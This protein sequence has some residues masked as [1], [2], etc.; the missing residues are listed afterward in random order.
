M[1]NNDDKLMEITVV[2]RSYND[3]DLLPLTLK[4]LDEQRGVK[5]ILSFLKVRVLMAQRRSSN[6]M[7]TLLSNI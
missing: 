1:L 5:Q 7:D 2:L 6:S 3:A 4:S